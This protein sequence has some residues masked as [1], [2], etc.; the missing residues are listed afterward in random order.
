MLALVMGGSGSGK[1]AY[2]EDL[3]VSLAGLRHYYLA[4]MIGEDDECAARIA[5]HQAQRR[6]KGFLTVEC[7][8]NL[9]TVRLAPESV[10]FLDC[11]S[12]LTANELFQETPPADGVVH[13][14][15]GL[16]QLWHM[17]R[18]LV[19]VSNTVFH[20]GVCY[21]ASMDYYLSVLG[22]LNHCLASQADLVVEVVYGL[23]VVQKGAA[24][25]LV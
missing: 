9:H 17:Q 5:R 3:A 2:G 15:R 21:D 1:S 19:I 7:S 22:R 13:I 6:E 8:R 12:N 16:E 18:H 20:D 24:Y 4:T 11:L 25:G 23:P 14:W 10:V